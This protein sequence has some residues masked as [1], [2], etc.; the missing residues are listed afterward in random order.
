MRWNEKFKIYQIEIAQKIMFPSIR[1]GDLVIIYFIS[2]FTHGRWAEMKVYIYAQ[3]K[4]KF[5]FFFEWKKHRV[6]LTFVCQYNFYIKWM[7][8][9]MAW[10]SLKQINVWYKPTKRHYKCIYARGK[11]EQ[12]FQNHTLV[13]IPIIIIIST[14]FDL[15]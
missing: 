8:K 13:F 15:I 9:S 7:I 4:S 3:L 10:V 6:K 14:W 11:V 12:H 5:N 2:K 1:I